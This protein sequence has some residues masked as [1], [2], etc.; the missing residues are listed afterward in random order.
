LINSQA[1]AGFVISVFAG[2]RL[3]KF[4]LDD[5]QT[6]EFLGLSTPSCTVFIAGLM[7]VYE[8]N[9][10]GLAD[11]ILKP[12]FLYSVVVVFSILLVA[13]IP[14]F[15]FK[16]KNMRWQGNENRFSFIIIALILLIFLKELAFS[17][18]ILLYVLYS[19]T[20]YFVKKTVDRS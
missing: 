10:A 15:S 19:L 13:E 16:F 9:T 3:A 17:L 2:L 1:F 20:R 18:I 11:F 5:R 4:N 12:M 8:F 6:E 7:L 14:M